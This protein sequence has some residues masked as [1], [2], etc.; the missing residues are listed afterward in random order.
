VDPRRPQRDVEERKGAG[1]RGGRGRKGDIVGGRRAIA[2]P[3]QGRKELAS[4]HAVDEY[5]HRRIGS[6]VAVVVLVHRFSFSFSFFFLL[7]C[8]ITHLFL[9]HPGRV[10]FHYPFA[11]IDVNFNFLSFIIDVNVNFVSFVANNN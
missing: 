7:F 9:F 3:E 6:V 11:I 2:F 4:H 5:R 10:S 8:G 1:R